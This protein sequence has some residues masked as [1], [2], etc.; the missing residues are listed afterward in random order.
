MSPDIECLDT[1]Q[2]LTILYIRITCPQDWL[3][4]DY[5]TQAL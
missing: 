5:N 1:T 4:S 2:S 3:H